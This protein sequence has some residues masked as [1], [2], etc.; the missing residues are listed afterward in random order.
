MV[1]QNLVPLAN[2]AV[3]LRVWPRL[4]THW[5]TPG[6]RNRALT[7]SPAFLFTLSSQQS[8]L[9][10]AHSRRHKQDTEVA[11]GL[12]AARSSCVLALDSQ[13]EIWKWRK[14]GSRTTSCFVVYVS[15]CVSLVAD[16]NGSLIVVEQDRGTVTSTYSQRGRAG[17]KSLWRG[18]GCGWL[19]GWGD[20]LN[21][22]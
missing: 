1:E 7:E 4:Q 19:A 6:T 5:K 20:L 21:Y 9:L 3:I 11:C 8:H 14:P 12:R 13:Q 22:A 15:L 16:D 2:S 10:S 18:G 17:W